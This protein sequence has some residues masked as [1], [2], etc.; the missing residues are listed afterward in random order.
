MQ[1]TERI[2]RA[3]SEVLTKIISNCFHYSGFQKGSETD[4]NYEN[5]YLSN[6]KSKLEAAAAAECNFLLDLHA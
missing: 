4:L 2:Q 5:K 6:L 3:W 1:S